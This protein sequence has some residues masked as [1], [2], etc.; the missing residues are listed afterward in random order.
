MHEVVDEM[1]EKL[2]TR[3]LIA[4]EDLGDSTPALRAFV[5]GSGFPSVSVPAKPFIMRYRIPIP[6][7]TTR[8]TM[9]VQIVPIFVL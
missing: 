3:P 7:M 2:A 5:E 6:P 1:T 9:T 4:A 8:L